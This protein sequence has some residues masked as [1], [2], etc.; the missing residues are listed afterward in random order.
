MTM[1]TG[2]LLFYGGIAGVILFGILFAA[3]W[4]VYEKKKKECENSRKGFFEHSISWQLYFGCITSGLPGRSIFFRTESA[5]GKRFHQ[6][7]C[8]GACED[9]GICALFCDCQRV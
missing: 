5:G 6:S 9:R 4:A 2:Q 7:G 8:F 3:S 1:T